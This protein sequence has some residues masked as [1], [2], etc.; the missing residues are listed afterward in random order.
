MKK[1][2]L[3]KPNVSYHR[4]DTESEKDATHLKS[5]ICNPLATGIGSHPA[6]LDDEAWIRAAEQLI[7]EEGA[8]QFLVNMLYLLRES[9]ADGGLQLAEP[10]LCAHDALPIIDVGGD[11]T[12]IGEYVF[13]HLFNTPVT[14]LISEPELTLV[15]QNGHTMPL[16]CPDCGKSLHINDEDILL[17]TL[18]GLTI[19]DLG[20]DPDS[21]AVILD[22]GTFPNNL[23]ADSAFIDEIDDVEPLDSLNVHLD[24]IRGITCPHQH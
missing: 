7:T 3:P 8:A 13:A 5:L 6:K 15:F 21:G 22:F 9:N 24:S 11:S 17:N 12:C 14:D 23:D 4:A 2:T 18:N 1:H 16:L 10:L 20:Y 19:I